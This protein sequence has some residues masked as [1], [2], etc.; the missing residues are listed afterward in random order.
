M[1]KPVYVFSGFLDSGKTTVIR[2]SLLNPRFNEGEKTLI[3]AME[4]GDVLYDEK[5]LRATHSE[6][7][8]L[9]GISELTRNKMQQLDQ[10]YRPERI[11]IELN[12]M[13]DDNLLYKQGF[14]RQWELAQTMTIF[15]AENFRLYMN[16]M[17]QFVFNHVVNAEMV[18][19]NRCKEDDILF[20][21]NNMKGINQRVEVIFEGKNGELFSKIEDKLF[22]V[23]KP[24]VIDD[25]D[26]GLW[27]MDAVDNPLKYDN[28]RITLKVKYEETIK[29]YV[30]TVIMGRKAMVCCANDIQTLALTVVN[31]DPDKINKDGYQSVSGTIHCLKDEEGYDTCV[32]Y[33]DKVEEAPYP[34]E[35]LVNFN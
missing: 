27:Y 23:S 25:L 19:F 21:R 14:I 31:V 33:A 15:N 11:F 30:N 7:T 12:G 26:Y 5:F 1:A 34:K 17:K 16:N 6:V 4:Q 20:L 2:E 10:K 28:A 9:G 29:E 22:D 35:E 32:L 8:Y 3:I 24:L 18:I 13:E